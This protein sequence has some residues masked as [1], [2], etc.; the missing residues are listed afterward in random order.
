MAIVGQFPSH[1][2]AMRAPVNPL[3]KSTVV[4]IFPREI[5][6]IKHTLIPG[7]F[8]IPPGSYENPSILVVGPSSW[9]RD[10]D[11]DQ[12]LIEIPVSSVLI[13]K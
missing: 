9:W 7:E 6:E 8:Y 12:P 10:I 11:P 3:D 4:S 13:A 2:M 5:H 1:R